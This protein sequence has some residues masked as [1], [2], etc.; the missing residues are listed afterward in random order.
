LPPAPA[1]NTSLPRDRD[2]NFI[3]I[4]A[5]SRTQNSRLANNKTT[6]KTDKPDVV[7]APDP[8]AS[9]ESSPAANSTSHAVDESLPSWAKAR[10][11]RDK[12]SFFVVVQ[13]ESTDPMIREQLLDEKMVLE[14][15]RYIDDM[16]YHRS[17]VSA[18]VSI[19]PEYLRENCLRNQYPTGAAAGD[20]SQIFAQLEFNSKF[21]KEVDDRY[22]KFMSLDRVQG[23]GAFAA[24]A[25][26]VLG[27]LYA[28][29]RF[30]PKRAAA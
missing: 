15:N 5:P 22:R 11:Y 27:G 9:D 18:M 28:F 10:P 7:E 17:G 20:D 24:A 13:A 3:A 25:L 4:D 8:S 19:T 6:S 14:A 12:D 16:L 29:L 30:S 1:P 26:A 23:L 21:K 2:G